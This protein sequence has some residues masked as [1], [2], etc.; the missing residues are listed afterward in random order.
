[1]NAKKYQAPISIVL[2]LT[3]LSL[4]LS[5][6]APLPSPVPTLSSADPAAPKLLPTDT[7]ALVLLPTD[8]VSPTST[9]TPVPFPKFSLDHRDNYFS[10]DGKPSFILSRNPT[11]KIKADFDTLLDWAH[12]GGSKVIRV[13]LTHGWWADPWINKD[14]TVNEKWAQDWDG[15]LTRL[16]R[17]AFT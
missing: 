3:V 7:E 4:F 10:L 9:V 17:T 8:T 11:G 12:Q 14:W 1:M 15:F 6:C 16:R 2:V 5:S 13:H